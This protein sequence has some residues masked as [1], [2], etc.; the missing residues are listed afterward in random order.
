VPWRR[1]HTEKIAH[2][3]EKK[4]QAEIGSIKADILE[5]RAR[6][7]RDNAEAEKTAAEAAR[8]REETEKLRL[9]NEK[10]QLELIA[11]KFQLALDLLS[12]ISPSLPDTEKTAFVVKLLPVLDTLVFSE[13]E[14][15]SVKIT[16]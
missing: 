7:A 3:E 6:A 12:Q 8:Q 16:Q 1:R 10:L 5:K 2:L 9:D 13:L 15:E 14:I 11:S 4:K